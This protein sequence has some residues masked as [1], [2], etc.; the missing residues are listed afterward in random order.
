MSYRYPSTQI[1]E[2]V[3]APKGLID[4]QTV[5]PKKKG[6]KGLSFEAFLEL[7]DGSFT[8]LMFRGKAGVSNEP[9]TYDSNIFL[10]QQRIQGVGYCSVAR[11]NFRAKDRIPEGW[12]QNIVNPNQPTNSSAYN[13]HEPLPD[14][15]P[16]DFKD[17]TRKVAELW[18]IDLDWEGELL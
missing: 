14:F 15:S 1:Y 12:H 10:D 7:L 16:T 6:T 8:D 9:E 18:N 17:F 2:F 13:L 11:K 3:K 5:E 4:G